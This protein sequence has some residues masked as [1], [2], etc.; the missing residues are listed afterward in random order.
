ME[1]VPGYRRRSLAH[2]IILVVKYW[3]VW[4]GRGR[5]Q[6]HDEPPPHGILSEANLPL[7]LKRCLVPRW[8]SKE[9]TTDI[10]QISAVIIPHL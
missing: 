6:K 4:T 8:R 2:E 3:K 9:D 7:T 1:G 5:G 10:Y